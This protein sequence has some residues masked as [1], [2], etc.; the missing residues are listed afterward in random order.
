MFWSRGS[1]H[2]DGQRNAG[3]WFSPLICERLSNR[4]VEF[5]L[6]RDCDLISSGSLLQRLNKSHRLHR[7]GFRRRLNIWGTGCLRAEDRL[8][9][10]HTLHAIRGRHSL[11]QC[12]A[13]VPTGVLGDPGILAGM[14]V[15]RQ[16]VPRTG[17]GLI[18]HMTDR[19]HPD[20]VAFLAANK[21]A[22]LIHI[23]SPVTDLL[24]QIAQCERIVSSSLHGLVFA[25]ALGI[26]NQWFTA[27][28][29]LIGGRHK[30]DDY[31]SIFDIRP[32]PITLPS[33]DLAT[34]CE[35]YARPGLEARKQA[36]IESF[37]YR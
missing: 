12:D 13:C 27:S 37:P 3:D 11:A 21:E 7:L 25:D 2:Q 35:D 18:P 20:V 14:I 31:Y 10:S 28:N 1:R 23:T 4:P 9:G 26:P 29:R 15:P 6:P 8:L 30:F 33:A 34:L 36:L 22:K 32:D 19:D 16:Q 24:E 17:L 5:A